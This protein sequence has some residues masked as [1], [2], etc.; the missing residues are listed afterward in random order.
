MAKKSKRRA[1]CFRAPVRAYTRTARRVMKRAYIR[2]VPD[3]RI[4]K[5]DIGDPNGEYDYEVSM[6]VTEPRRIRD[7]SLEAMRVA[8]TRFMDKKAGKN[9]YYLKV[10]VYPHQVL[11]E[12]SFSGVAGADRL[13][14]GMKR[15]FGKVVGRAAQVK[16]GTKIMS[17]WV[18][19]NHLDLAKQALKR[20]FSKCTLHTKVEIEEAKKQQ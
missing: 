17:I 1:R 8:I 13:S 7:T 16:E 3:P 10:R 14:K 18:K 19:K 11:R 5:F 12:H 15:A 4:R 9:T 20:I 2:G 6:V